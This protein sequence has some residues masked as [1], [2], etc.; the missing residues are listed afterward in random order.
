[1]RIG[2]LAAATGTTTKT[3]RFYEDSGLLPPAGR[4]PS[5]YRDYNDDALDRLDFIRRGRAA[6]LT[7]KQIREIIVIR[8]TG[9]A[10]CEHVRDLLDTRLADLHRQISDLQAL[11]DSV[12]HLREDVANADPADCHAQEVCRYL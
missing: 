1:M 2:E 7:L 11:R 6:G 10:P 4:T 8:D 9:T 5:G 3:L 12:A